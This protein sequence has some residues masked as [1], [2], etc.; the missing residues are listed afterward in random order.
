MFILCC[1]N[2][3]AQM[4]HKFYLDSLNKALSGNPKEDK[5]RVDI[6]NRLSWNYR[7]I[8][9][10]LGIE[11]GKKA[12]ELALK[13]DYTSGYHKALSYVGVNYKNQGNFIKAL[14]YFIR[15]SESCIEEKDVENEG[16][17]YVNMG[18]IYHLEHNFPRAESSFKKAEEIGLK[19][20]DDVLL[21]YVY[22][23]MGRMHKDKDKADF[24][25]AIDYLLK[26]ILIRQKLKDEL[27]IA[28]VYQ[29]MAEIYTEQGEYDQANEFFSKSIA[30]GEKFEDKRSIASNN[31]GLANLYVKQK[32]YKE[33]TESAQKS[34]EY[35][36][37]VGDQMYLKEAYF[38]LYKVYNELGDYKTALEYQTKYITSKDSLFS[39]EASQKIQNLETVT[40]SE[41]N[42][43]I[44]KDK[45][46]ISFIVL[47]VSILCW[48][49]LIG[50]ISIFYVKNRQI[51]KINEVLAQKND[52]I[53]SK[54]TELQN[55][56]N[57]I[58]YKNSN[59]TQSMQ[60]AQRIQ[61]A[62]L[63]SL[64]E[65]NAFFPNNFIL[66]KPRDIVGGD[67]YWLAK[68]ENVVYLACA[69]CTG[70]GVSGALLAS[71]SN[72]IL[73]KVFHEKK[74]R[75]V[76]LILS[77][78]HAEI[79]KTLNQEYTGGREGMDILLCSFDFTNK[80]ANF[81]GAN[82]YIYYCQ[83]ETINIL[84][85]NK[86]GIGGMVDIFGV[87]RKYD[88]TTIDISLPTTFYLSTDG[89]QDQFGGPS[90]QKYMR[91]QFTMLLE[92]I[93]NDNMG[94]QKELLKEIFEVWKQDREQTDDVLVIGLKV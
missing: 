37:A 35:L 23:N 71:I 92:T 81:A 40:L 28:A 15:T 3:G 65:F 57:E 30:I 55:A 9:P 7:N 75:D 47:I 73:N 85:G 72:M 32:K 45:E 60:Y 68:D 21:A 56:F 90:D 16:Y 14:E 91:K 33:A 59:I 51:K 41:K 66:N 39:E 34:I 19:L 64:L 4:P 10:T 11:Y 79:V 54:S 31:A 87:K 38:A 43:T 83:N 1:T 26:S 88:K 86:Y 93:H 8:K 6:L 29:N 58:E 61:Q 2:A 82:H 69:D 53:R 74:V 80:T 70:H 12:S 67:F 44:Q 46:K 17:S 25:V 18:M 22:L 89:Y 50:M 63:P 48:I 77:E 52:Q 49:F 78:T 76:G 20:K 94:D 36:K 62:I 84:R 24:P 13:L 27:G 5:K 42:K